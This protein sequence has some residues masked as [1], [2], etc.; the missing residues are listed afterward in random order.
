[1]TPSQ[2]AKSLGCKSLAQVVETS[3]QSIQTLINWHH[4]KPKLFEVV[5]LGVAKQQEQ[6]Q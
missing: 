6:Q 5:C 4:N 1:M 2:K 3:G